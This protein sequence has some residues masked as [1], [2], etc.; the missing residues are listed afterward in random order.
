[1][2]AP[3]F[4]DAFQR[5]YCDPAIFEAF[6][7]R[8]PVNLNRALPFQPQD[9]VVDDPRLLNAELAHLADQND[10]SRRAV[11]H[12]YAR[13][14]LLT[15]EDAAN[16]K[17]VVDF[18]AS[19]FFDLMGLVYANAG[20]YICA[21]RWYREYILRLETLKTEEI[22]G[23]DDEGVYASVGYSLYSLGMFEEAI[24]WTKSCIGPLLEADTAC[25]A[26]IESEVQQLGATLWAIESATNRVRY[27]ISGPEPA[28]AGSI[29]EQLKIGI[30]KIAPH[31]ESYFCWMNNPPPQLQIQDGYPF[32]MDRRA[33]HFLRHKM[34]LL[35]SLCSAAD[36]LISN[37]GTIE[38]RQLLDEAATLEPNAQFIQERL[39]ALP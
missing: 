39:Q 11:I 15:D 12:E 14:G 4:S 23:S 1:M 35:F 22:R 37:G 32:S 7:T 13:S 20:M 28:N 24:A 3:T 19:D 25:R 21:L 27:A 2:N 5:L 8:Y 36:A 31:Q 6:S 30:K 38:A 9:P 34:N 17:P 33:T 18:F 10:N 16:V 29:C 26:F